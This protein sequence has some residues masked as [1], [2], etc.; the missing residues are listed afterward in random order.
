M[1]YGHARRCSFAGGRLEA[2][3]ERRLVFPPSTPLKVAHHTLAEEAVYVSA[4]Q[5]ERQRCGPQPCV[6]C[7]RIAA[8]L[9]GVVA[10]EVRRNGGEVRSVRL[11]AVRLICLIHD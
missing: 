6:G 8:L 3:W 4:S 9:A 11:W 2:T 10:P 5:R 1:P 7:P